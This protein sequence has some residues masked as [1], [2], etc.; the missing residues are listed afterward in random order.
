MCH[1]GRVASPLPRPRPAARGGVIRALRWL[2]RLPPLRSWLLVMSV[3]VG[4]SLLGLR[5]VAFL[6]AVAWSA[7]AVFTWLSPSV[8]YRL[9]RWSRR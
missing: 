5:P 3:I 8:R 7:Y 2:V 1:D 4:L 6:V 9:G